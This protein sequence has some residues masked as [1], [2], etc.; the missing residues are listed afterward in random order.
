[1]PK[2]PY[3]VDIP[4][5]WSDMDALRHINNV[6]IVR[7][8]EEARVLGLADWFGHDS[9]GSKVPRLVIARTE[10]EYRQQLHYRH[11]PVTVTMWVSHMSGASFDLDY[12]VLASDESDAEVCCVARTT[13]VHF[14]LDAQ[15][16]R[17]VDGEM[18]EVLGRYADDPVA[19][20]RRR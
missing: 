1:M 4:L 15:R 14:D 5:R 17:R 3:S 19:L 2:R 6:Q 11:R 12:E 8:L 20:R 7:L 18:A 10:I 13:V 16:P 9:E